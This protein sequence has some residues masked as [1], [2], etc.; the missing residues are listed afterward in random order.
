MKLKSGL[1]SDVTQ[2]TSSRDV[3]THFRVKSLLS[4]IYYKLIQ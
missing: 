3:M 4:V 1:K 2:I